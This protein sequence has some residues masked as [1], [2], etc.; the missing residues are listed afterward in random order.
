LH[1]QIAPGD[2]RVQAATT[3]WIL[4][5][6]KTSLLRYGQRAARERGLTPVWIT[7]GDADLLPVL[8]AELEKLTRAWHSAAAQEIASLI[9][10][11]ELS[12]SVAGLGATTSPGQG[13]STAEAPGQALE[14]LIAA[15]AVEP[16][17]VV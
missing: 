14:A 1:R 15:T 4:K 16:P 10:N 3:P 6:R 8:S 9:R 2:R 11:L 7:A 12:V 5:S 13:R 17:I